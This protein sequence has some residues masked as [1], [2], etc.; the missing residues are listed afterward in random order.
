MTNGQEQRQRQHLPLVQRQRQGSHQ[1]YVHGLRRHRPLLNRREMTMGIMEKK[2]AE[3][4]A[5]DKA[6]AE[7]MARKIAAEKEQDRQDRR[8]K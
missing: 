7:E 5:A 8:G 3:K 2:A 6:R 1:L 4:F